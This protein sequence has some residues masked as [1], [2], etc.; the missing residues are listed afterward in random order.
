MCDGIFF[1]GLYHF[2]IGVC[3]AEC[4]PMSKLLVNGKTG[5][6]RDGFFFAISLMC[7]FLGTGSSFLGGNDTFKY[8]AF[9]LQLEILLTKQTFSLNESEE[10]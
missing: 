9:Q 1:S 2:Q 8:L 4:S 10:R 3:G 7:P 6:Q 5:N